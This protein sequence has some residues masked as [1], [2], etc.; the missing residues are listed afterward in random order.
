MPGYLRFHTIPASALLISLFACSTASTALAATHT[1]FLTLTSDGSAQYF[2]RSVASGRDVNGDGY[3]DVLIGATLNGPGTTLLGEVLLYFGGPGMDSIPD[4]TIPSEPDYAAGNFGAYGTALVD[5]NGDG[6]A[7]VVAGNIYGN[8]KGQVFV[9]FGGPAMDAIPDLVLSGTFTGELFGFAISSAGDLNGDGY[10]DLVVTSPNF[11][12]LTDP[13]AEVQGRAY[14]YFGGPTV[15]ATPDLILETPYPKVRQFSTHFGNAVAPAGD[16]NG[17]GMTD[18]VVGYA[19]VPDA[20]PCCFARAFIYYG[21]HSLDGSPD[22][23]VRS[24]FSNGLNHSVSGAGDF[25]G[26]GYDDVALTGH[27]ADSTGV[28]STRAYLYFGGPVTTANP[29]PNLILVGDPSGHQFGRTILGGRDLNGDGKPDLLIGDFGRA[30]VFYGGAGADSVPD[31]VVCALFERS[32]FGARMAVGDLNG[33]GVADAVVTATDYFGGSGHVYVFDV[34]SPLESR[35]LPRHG[36]ITLNSGSPPVC[37]RFEPVN[38]SY[39]NADVDPASLRLVSPGTG[40]VGEI[41]AIPSKFP[42]EGD[43]DRNGIAELAA[44]FT[45]ADLSRLFSTIRGRRTVEVALEGRLVRG[46]RFRAPLSLAVAGGGG[47]KEPNLSLR[48][49]P[50]N[51]T[52]TL[53]F[54]TV[55]LGRVTVRLFDVRGR[56]VRRVWTSAFTDAGIHD[57]RID[58]RDDRGSALASGVYFYRIESSDGVLGG[59]I[60]IAK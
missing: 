20:G 16:L 37:L 56:C 49:N 47:G 44:C 10:E 22:W 4:L 35:A 30:F 29:T 27:V 8:S 26:D 55:N 1:P 7:D 43:T 57:V 54:E 41:S 23:A 15:D 59:R 17:D 52:G 40:D 34:S 42:D 3:E 53:S 38:G 14:I 18:L 2:A 50:F 19:E 58:G 28:I 11:I 13:E 45:K 6:Y 48:P 36:T 60:V 46:R 12:P 33:D 39:S 5:V 21:G 9:Y 31:D 51:P 24:S 25:N 32:D